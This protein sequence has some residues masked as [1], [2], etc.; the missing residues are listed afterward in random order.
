MRGDDNGNERV[1][2]GLRT[3]RYSIP[4]DWTR[5]DRLAVV[6]ELTLAKAAILALTQMPYQRSW[7]D[8]LQSI[9]LKR[10]VAGTSRIEGA[11]FT[12]KELDAAL[13]ETPEQ[14]ETRS[15]KQAAAAVAT[16]RWIAG[17]ENDRPVD[18]AL[19]RDVHRR[20]VTT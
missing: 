14:L 10:E 1:Y 9:Q 4:G 15:R 6:E 16:Y 11:D 17:L 3:L 7:A 2:S 5:Y 19:I 13:R 12:D 18:E 20:L 8:R